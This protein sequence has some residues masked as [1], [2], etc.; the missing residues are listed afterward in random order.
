MSVTANILLLIAVLLV[1]ILSHRSGKKK[2]SPSVPETSVK[3]HNTI[4]EEELTKKLAEVIGSLAETKLP[5]IRIKPLPHAP[6]SIWQ[7][8]FGGTPYWPLHMPYPETPSGKPLRLL[9]QLNLDE[10]PSLA[11]YPCSGI[12][13]FFIDTDDLMGLKFPKKG[14]DPVEVATRQEGFRV[15]YHKNIVR[16]VNQLRNTFPTFNEDCFPLAGP[17]ALAFSHE[18]EPVSPTDYRFERTSLYPIQLEDDDLADYLFEH[19]SA[20]GSKMGG[21]ANF[22]QDDPRGYQDNEEWVLL[23]QMDTESTGDIEIMWGDCGVG[24]FFIRPEEL[25]NHDFSKVWYSWDC[26]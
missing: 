2:S 21:Y 15:I 17:Y 12:L 26:C 16:D 11:G 10:M 4:S 6:A 18:E 5:Y 3:L 23:F 9:A 8:N 1:V 20:E 24:N 25:K 7:S 14:E 19:F 22:T 13:Q